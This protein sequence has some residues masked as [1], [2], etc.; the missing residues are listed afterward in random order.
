MANK[1]KTN[2]MS[3]HFKVIIR[4]L[5]PKV[6]SSNVVV[7]AL[8]YRPTICIDGDEDERQWSF[9][10]YFH[11]LPFYD[12]PTLAVGEFLTEFCPWGAMV[13][14]K[15]FTIC[16]GARVIGIGEV[17]EIAEGNCVPEPRS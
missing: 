15:C 17:I 6:K 16:E 1:L 12:Q 13:K 10:M 9:P 7:N 5:P 2:S 8:H 4:W 14:G 11:S 3:N